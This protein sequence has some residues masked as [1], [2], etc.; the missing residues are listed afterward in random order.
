MKK[1]KLPSPKIHDVELVEFCSKNFKE[2]IMSTGMSNEAII[3]AAYTLLQPDV[4]C[5]SVA[6]YPTQ[7]KNL[8]M[9][10]VE[11][12][13]NNYN[14]KVG[15]SGHDMNILSYIYAVYLG[16]EYIERHVCLTREDR[17]ISDNVFSLELCEYKDFVE[18][19]Q[20]AQ[21][22]YKMGD[23]ESIFNNLKQL[24]G[25]EALQGNEKRKVYECEVKKML[26]LRGEHNGNI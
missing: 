15:Y 12:L 3:Y 10:Y 26:E 18:N 6:E 13:K 24:L 22:C 9:G 19:I 2:K 5:H 23:Y 16:C 20:Q 8:N 14:C 4:L 1:I 7:N 21:L 25:E 11:W 17:W